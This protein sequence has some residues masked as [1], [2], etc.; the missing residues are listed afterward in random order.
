MR[1]G[2]GRRADV[3]RGR[4]SDICAFGNIYIYIYIYSI[5][6]YIYIRV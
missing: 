5:Y 2:T 1:R 3:E 4:L 6:L